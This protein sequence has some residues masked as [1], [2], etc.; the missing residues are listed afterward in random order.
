MNQIY[1][2]GGTGYFV[3]TMNVNAARGNFFPN[4]IPAMRGPRWQTVRAQQ[5]GG[6]C[7]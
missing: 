1:Q 4:Q 2:Q 3:P 5:A 7:K 6:A